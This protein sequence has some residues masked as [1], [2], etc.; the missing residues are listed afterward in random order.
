MGIKNPVTIT[1]PSGEVVDLYPIG[2]LAEELGRTSQSIRKWE[3]GGVLPDSM[4]RD[5]NG[6]RLYSR[7]QIDIIVECAEKAGIL[8]GRAMNNTTFSNNCYKRL[9]ELKKRYKGEN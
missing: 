1:T 3:I 7:E 9:E 4:F 5:K 8:Q 6:R 2:T